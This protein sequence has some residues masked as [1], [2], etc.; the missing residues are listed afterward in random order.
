MVSR[1]RGHR[2]GGR[3]NNQPPPAFDQQAFIEAISVIVA[4]IAQ[5]S[6]TGGQGGT[7]NL[8]RVKAHHPP[9]FKGEKI[10]MVADH[11]FRQVEKILEAMEITSNATRIKLATFQ[12]ESESQVWW[13]WVKAF[14]DLEAMTWEELC[15]L[16]MDKY[17]PIFGWYEKAREFLELRPG[18]MTVL[19]YMAKFTEL[20]RFVDDYVAIDMAKVRKFE[21]GLRLSIRSKTVGHLL[22][23]MDSMVKTIFSIEREVDDVRNIQDAG[24]K[25][26]RENQ[27]SSSS[28][29][30]K[31]RTSTP[32]QSQG[33]S[34]GY[35]GQGQDRSSQDG[36]CFRAPSQQGQ[37][38]CY[39]FH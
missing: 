6:A 3:D 31:H 39:F 25:D 16:F 32:H 12:L 14:R 11:W 30:K 34:R 19:K 35:Q 33:Q 18:T 15:E 27:P 37:W 36:R 13:D 38:T 5:T 23:D 24:V 8:Q 20:A 2:G 28:S 17:F 10:P 21:N 29:R 26:K 1:G 22:Q 9:T 4:T 7:S